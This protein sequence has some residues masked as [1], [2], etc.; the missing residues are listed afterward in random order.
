MQK[1][2]NQTTQ[3]PAGSCSTEAKKPAGSC[4]TEMKKD[5]KAGSCSSSSDKG[6]SGSCGG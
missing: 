6:K 5:E 4:G 2:E 3:K 1:Q